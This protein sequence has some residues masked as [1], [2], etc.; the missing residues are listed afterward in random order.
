MASRGRGRGRGRRGGGY[1]F[2]HPAKH[3]PHEDFPDITLP[4]MT[5]ARATMEEKA[6]IQSTLKFEDFWK[7]SCYHLEE[8]VPKKKNDDKEIERY[9]DRKRKTHSKREALASYLILTPANFPV[10]LVQGSKRG[11]PSSK[12]LRWDR[13]SD[14][15]AFEVFEKLEEKHKDGD[16]KTE[17]DGDDEDEHEEEEVEEENS[18]D[19]Y[20]QNIEFD[21]DD[22]DWNQEEEAHEDYYD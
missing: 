16:K 6:L 4:E 1:G 20:N 11:Q 7:T 8:D 17:K 5:C 9:S 12:K 14:D 2:D 21:D 22:D 10:E 19:D 15:Q 3:T 13:S 18:D